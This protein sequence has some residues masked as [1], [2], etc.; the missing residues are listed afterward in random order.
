MHGHF[1]SRDKDGGYTIRSAV[2][3]NHILHAN[4]TALCLIEREY[5][6]SKFYIVW[7]GIFDP[8]GSYDLDLDL[9][10]LI[11]EL[12]PVVRGDV[13]MCSANM[14]FLRQGFRKL[15]S[16]RHRQTDIQTRPKLYTAPLRGW[17]IIWSY[18]LMKHVAYYIASSFFPSLINASYIMNNVHYVINEADAKKGCPS[19]P[20]HPIWTVTPVG[21]YHLHPREIYCYSLQKLRCILSSHCHRLH[22]CKTQSTSKDL[23]KGTAS[24]KVR[25]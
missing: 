12:D 24:R 5:C 9:M 23:R 8:F 22:F 25:K 18:A 11:Y 1:R 16:Y 17:S 4:V 20:R 19:R 21:C 14:N 13:Q 2:P 3:A 7:I 6:Q 15:S 10:I